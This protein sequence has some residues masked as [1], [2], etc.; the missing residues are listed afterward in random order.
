MRFANVCVA[1]AFAIAALTT[2]ACSG[3]KVTGPSTTASV[4]SATSPASTAGASIAGT[5]VGVS[6]AASAPFRTMATGMT[7]TVTGTNLS[8]PVD[9]SGHFELH[10]VPAG[11]VEIRFS[12]RGADA[13]LAFDDVAEHEDIR[14]VVR[15]KG[16]TAE[17]EDN[18]RETPDN[19]AE[20]EGI[21][22]EVNAAAGTLRVGD[23][24]ISV[25]STAAVR[26]GSTTM[27]LADVRV[28]DRV[29]IHGTRTGTTIVATEVEVENE[30]A[31]DD[32]GGNPGDNHGP[33]PGDDHGGADHGAGV[34]LNGAVGGKTGTCPALSFSVGSAK[35]VTSSH[36]E[37]KDVTC[38]ALANNDQVEVKGSRRTDGAVDA[39]RVEKKR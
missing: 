24:L 6:G 38:G 19:R 20:V 9:D 28:G 32:H 1:G 26:H 35:V 39:T 5:V 21:V 25:P 29:H 27:H 15:V 23:T 3:N 2:A 13:A 33:D 16:T 8:S 14:V 17:I 34:E 36:T 4:T 37:F 7:V 12:G 22:G 11:R 30:H 10:G 31:G 18:H